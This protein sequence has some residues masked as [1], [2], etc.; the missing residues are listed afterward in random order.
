MPQW[1]VGIVDMKR[2][3]MPP[4]GKS[5]LEEFGLVMHVECSRNGE[6]RNMLI[7]FGFTS[8]TQKIT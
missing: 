5:P 4:V 8:E 3:G 6:T 2:F 1:K 7:D